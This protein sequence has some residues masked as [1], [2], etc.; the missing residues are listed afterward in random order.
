MQLGF[1]LQRRGPLTN[2]WTTCTQRP[3]T[4]LSILLS[5]SSDVTAALL[6]RPCLGWGGVLQHPILRV[7]PSFHCFHA[8]HA[9]FSQPI[10]LFLDLSLSSFSRAVTFRPNVGEEKVGLHRLSGAPQA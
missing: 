1:D 10:P 5:L 2:M 4:R 7:R 6:S 9:V 3:Y 8:P